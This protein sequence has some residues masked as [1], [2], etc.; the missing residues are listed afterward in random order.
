VDSHSGGILRDEFDY[1]KCSLISR[2]NRVKR[3]P[4]INKQT[5]IAADETTTRRA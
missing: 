3:Q 1:S 4:L 5:A 2:K